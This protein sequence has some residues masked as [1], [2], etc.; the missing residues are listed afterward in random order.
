MTLKV[1]NRSS[2]TTVSSLVSFL[3]SFLSL[4][5]PQEAMPQVN[6]YSDDFGNRYHGSLLG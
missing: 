5:S 1:I 3:I 6:L 4:M 2:P